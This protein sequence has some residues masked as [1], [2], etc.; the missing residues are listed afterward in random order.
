MC[1]NH[2]LQLC[3]WYK[4]SSG[5]SSLKWMKLLEHRKMIRSAILAIIH[6]N[7]HT[8]KCFL[9]P[10]HTCRG[11]EQGINISR[12]THFHLTLT[13]LFAPP[14]KPS[15]NIGGSLYWF[16]VLGLL[17]SKTQMSLSPWCFLKS[18]VPPL[19]VAPGYYYPPL[20][21]WWLGPQRCDTSWCGWSCSAV[22]SQRSQPLR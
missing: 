19:A 15:E 12:S 10:L 16:A 6:W 14:P 1:M 18:P 11:Y 3:L 5:F 8:Q 17:P 13:S 22:S 9:M 20:K 21:E 7:S 2:F 4:R